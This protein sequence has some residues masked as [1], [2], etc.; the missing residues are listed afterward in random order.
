[1]VLTLYSLDAKLIIYDVLIRNLYA[2]ADIQLL[3]P[4]NDPTKNNEKTFCKTI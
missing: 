2:K 1:M 4:G 3:L